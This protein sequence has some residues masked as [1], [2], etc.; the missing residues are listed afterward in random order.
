MNWTEEDEDIGN[1]AKGGLVHILL[2][3][4]YI[5]PSLI[6]TLSETVIELFVRHTCA[7]GRAAC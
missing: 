2:F 1:E 6:S 4:H 7:T 3:W 5:I